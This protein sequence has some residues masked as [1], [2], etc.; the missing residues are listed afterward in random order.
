MRK[1]KTL[2]VLGAVLLNVSAAA[3][4][5][6]PPQPVYYVSMRALTSEAAPSF[7]TVERQATAT[8]TTAI[9]GCD[10]LTYYATPSDAQTVATARANGDVVQLHRAM[11]SDAPQNSA[12]ICIIDGAGN[13]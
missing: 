4:A 6:D 10:E 8:R 3:Q 5:D 1:L 11:P 12:I 9:A 13:T 2:V 7:V